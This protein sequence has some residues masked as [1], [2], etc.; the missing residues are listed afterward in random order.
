MTIT[1]GSTTFDNVFFDADVGVLYLHKGDPS[2]ASSH[3]WTSGRRMARVQMVAYTKKSRVYAIGLRFS[4][5][6]PA[7]SRSE[8]AGIAEESR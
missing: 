8:L 2:T 4:W 7:A 6:G 5:Y 3:C 1:I